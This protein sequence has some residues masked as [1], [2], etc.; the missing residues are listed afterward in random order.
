MPLKTTQE[1]TSQGPVSDVV[2]ALSASLCHAC[3]NYYRKSLILFAPFKTKAK[4]CTSPRLAAT[5]PVQWVSTAIRKTYFFLSRNTVF[6]T[7][8]VSIKTYSELSHL[9]YVTPLNKKGWKS[10]RW[11]WDQV[12]QEWLVFR[13]NLL[14]MRL[15][16]SYYITTTAPQDPM[17]C[18]LWP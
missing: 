7:T 11:V 6:T 15:S 9:K 18:F 2:C 1:G 4:Q 12:A 14:N 3:W 8:G 10:D 13:T 16:N 5:S 17:R